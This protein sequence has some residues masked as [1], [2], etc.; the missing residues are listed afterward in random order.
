MV[1]QCNSFCHQPFGFEKIYALRQVLVRSEV[2][3]TMVYECSGAMFLLSLCLGQSRFGFLRLF[4]LNPVGGMQISI[5]RNNHRCFVITIV[6]TYLSL[7]FFA[8]ENKINTTKLFST[9]HTSVLYGHPA[10][11]CLHCPPFFHIYQLRSLP[12]PSFVL[13]FLLTA[14]S[15][16]VSASSAPMPN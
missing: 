7:A 2:N 9:P 8:K 14:I 10:H 5:V 12:D 11:F 13:L 16:R 15:R 1:C 4:L 3:F 6:F